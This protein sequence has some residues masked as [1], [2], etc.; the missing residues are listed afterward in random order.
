MLT[1]MR[2]ASLAR[3]VLTSALL[4]SLAVGIILAT[5]RLSISPPVEYDGPMSDRL[6]ELRNDGV[7]ATVVRRRERVRQAITSAAQPEWAG[8]YFEGDGLGVNVNL[9][10]ARGAGISATWFGCMGLYG[11]NE[12]DVL[13][14]PGDRLEFRFGSPNGKGGQVPI[15]GFPT[16]VTLVRWGERRYLLADDQMMDF[17]NAMHQGWEPRSDLH[18]MFLL[19]KGDEEKPAPG[20]PTLPERYRAYLRS[21]ALE[22]K[23]SRVE[24]GIARGSA[25]FPTCVYRVHFA[26]PAGARLA[27][28]LEFKVEFP[29]DVHEQFR[30]AG[31]VGSDVLAEGTVYDSCLSA[32]VRPTTDWVLTSGSF[33]ARDGKAPPIAFKTDE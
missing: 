29:A 11:A 32:S 30:V 33:S 27:E 31:L 1:W 28:G 6:L 26:L 25:E 19:A 21:K 13:E 8:E 24:P 16:S 4:A 3:I 14:L 15:G 22:V 2:Q 9:S 18:G 20:L 23:L 12:G 10:L 7:P 17:V 5:V